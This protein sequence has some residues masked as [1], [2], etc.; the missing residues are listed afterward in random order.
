M[1]ASNPVF[2]LS[3]RNKRQKFDNAKLKNTPKPCYSVYSRPTSLRWL[4]SCGLNLVPMVLS[5][6]GK[7][8]DEV[9][10]TFLTL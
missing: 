7:E 5:G 6:H 9:G 4:L 3:A 1:I 2:V 10:E 8:V